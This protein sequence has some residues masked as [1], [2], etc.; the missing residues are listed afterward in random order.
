MS[1]AFLRDSPT[2]TGGDLPV[3]GSRSIQFGSAG[4]IR[5]QDFARSEL[6]SSSPAF[7][8]TLPSTSALAFAHSHCLL[9]T[10]KMAKIKKKG[11]SMPAAR[12]R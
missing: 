3:V 10:G 5:R 8:V 9:T 1:S 6:R 11:K 7:S 12:L 4:S 2:C